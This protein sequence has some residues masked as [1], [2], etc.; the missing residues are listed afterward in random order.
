MNKTYRLPGFLLLAHWLTFSISFVWTCKTQGNVLW[1]LRLNWSGWLSD[2]GNLTQLGTLPAGSAWI[3]W[4][5]L[6]LLLT[7]TW[8]LSPSTSV[9]TSQAE[10]MPKRQLVGNAEMM[11]SRPGLQE[12][13][14]R[15]HQSLEKI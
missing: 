3:M 5:L 12:K 14:L 15:L 1:W 8:I 6:G 13:L 4:F 2:F 7:L 10:P 11:E 9:Q